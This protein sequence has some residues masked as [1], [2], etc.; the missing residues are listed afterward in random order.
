VVVGSASAPAPAAGR[1][2]HG[3][4]GVFDG[5]VHGDDEAGGLGGR[6]QCIDAHDGRLPHAGLE[7]IGD[8]LVVHVHAV[9]HASL[10]GE[11][12]GKRLSLQGS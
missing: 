1:G 9:P 11:R 7:V 12:R 5:F 2:V 6:C 10:G 8:V 4:T 3:G